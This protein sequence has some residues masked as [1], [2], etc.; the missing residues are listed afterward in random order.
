MAVEISQNLTQVS[1]SSAGVSGVNGT[2]GTSGFLNL[3]NDSDNRVI[4]ANGDGTG[5]AEENLSFDGNLLSVAGSGSF[6]GPLSVNKSVTTQILL[7]P[8]LLEGDI[9]VPSGYNGMLVG[10]VSNSGS[11]SIYTD[12]TLVII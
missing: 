1:I 11:L 12:S 10:P 8:Q 6:S 2:S 4:T 5:N 7:N 9:E 3:D